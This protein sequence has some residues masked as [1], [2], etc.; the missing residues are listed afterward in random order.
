MIPRDLAEPMEVSEESPVRLS[1][2][3]RQLVVEPEDDIASDADFQ[4]ALAV[5]LR[6]HR[7]AFK[8]LADYDRGVRKK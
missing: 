3:G 6:K 4:R 5:V 7:S 1:L 8:A 2:V